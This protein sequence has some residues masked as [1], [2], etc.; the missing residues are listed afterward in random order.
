MGS[1]QTTSQLAQLLQDVQG[2]LQLLMGKAAAHC[3]YNLFSLLSACFA[4]G[5]IDIARKLI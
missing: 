3:S 2:V 1:E 4:H 5:H